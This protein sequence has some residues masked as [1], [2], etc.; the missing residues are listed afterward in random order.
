MKLRFFELAKR[1]SQKSPSKYKLGCVIVY[2]NKVVNVGFNDMN[3]THPKANSAYKTL[4]AEIDALI[5][6]E[7]NIAKYCVVYLYREYKNGKPALAKPCSTCELALKRA[8]IRH[9]FYTTDDGP[10]KLI[11]E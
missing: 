11:L 9:V 2:K 4:H 1:I 3:K 6:L 5:G 8:G 7:H 10:Q